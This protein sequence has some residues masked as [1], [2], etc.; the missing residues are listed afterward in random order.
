MI[1]CFIYL[2]QSQSADLRSDYIMNSAL[3]G[4]EQAD[5]LLLIGANPRMEVF[6]SYLNFCYFEYHIHLRKFI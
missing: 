5:A 1:V 4:V 6:W 3:V 2:N